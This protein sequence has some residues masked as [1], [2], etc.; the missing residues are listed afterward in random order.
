MF[1]TDVMLEIINTQAT[2]ISQITIENK[3]LRNAYNDRNDEI[4]A[5]RRELD[6]VKFKK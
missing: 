6:I 2:T 5:L 1:R 3:V 4:V